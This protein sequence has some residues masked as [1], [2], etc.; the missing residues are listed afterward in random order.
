MAMMAPAVFIK[1]TSS[2]KSNSTVVV[3]SEPHFI[4]KAVSFSVF[5]VV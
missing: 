4:L 3:R 1:I 2:S 5:L